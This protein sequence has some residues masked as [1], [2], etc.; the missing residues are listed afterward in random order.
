MEKFRVTFEIEGTKLAESFYLNKQNIEKM[1]LIAFD[2]QGGSPLF[3]ENMNTQVK[4]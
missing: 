1:M 4:I 3:D 2:E